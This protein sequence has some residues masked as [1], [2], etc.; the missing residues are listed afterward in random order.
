M[1]ESTVQSSS[2]KTAQG[3]ACVEEYQHDWPQQI[4]WQALP[5]PNRDHPPQSSS[6]PL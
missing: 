3:Q 2:Y 4:D 1:I 6:E 5:L